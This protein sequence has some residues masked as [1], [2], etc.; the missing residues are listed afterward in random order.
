MV[1]ARFVVM[2]VFM[3]VL[4]LLRRHR[5]GD[6]RASDS[7]DGNETAADGPRR[8]AGS[9]LHGSSGIVGIRHGPAL[10][11]RGLPCRGAVRVTSF[12]ELSL[13]GAGWD[14]GG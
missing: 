7:H 11:A 12:G 14:K 2:L 3:F 13:R 6:E 9:I 10:T 5:D 4:V 1:V 8:R